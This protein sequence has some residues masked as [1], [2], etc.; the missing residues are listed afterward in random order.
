MTAIAPP[1][2]SA[3][4]QRF[5]ENYITSIEICKRLGISRVALGQALR[6][7]TLPKPIGIDGLRIHLWQRQEVEGALQQW[8]ADIRNRRG[9]VNG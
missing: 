2:P 7:G 1:P 3:A 8:E 4:Q 6:R 9:V 5:N